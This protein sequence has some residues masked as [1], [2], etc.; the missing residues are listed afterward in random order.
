LHAAALRNRPWR[1]ATGPRTP[2]GKA[3]AALNGKWRQ[4]EEQS[5]REVRRELAGLDGVISRL[6]ELRHALLGAFG[7]NDH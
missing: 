1:H 5:V 7:P 2:A 6:A 3:K 4:F